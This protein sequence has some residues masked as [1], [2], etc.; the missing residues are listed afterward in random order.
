[1]GAQ[2]GHKPQKNS[3]LLALWLVY[4]F[5]REQNFQSQFLAMHTVVLATN[6]FKKKESF[7]SRTSIVSDSQNKAL[8]TELEQ[9]IQD[10][11]SSQPLTSE[12]P[13]TEARLGTV[14]RPAHQ[15]QQHGRQPHGQTSLPSPSTGQPHPSRLS[16][17]VP[18]P[19][20]SLDDA[21][22]LS[23]RV[24]VRTGSNHARDS[25]TSLTR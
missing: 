1:M 3:L 7:K 5:G 23:G 24:L 17:T 18:A 21:Q 25:A 14:L 9:P 2:E 13:N 10:Q 6:K 8:Y 16:E 20:S 4:A 19:R 22:A 11:Q 12:L 15:L